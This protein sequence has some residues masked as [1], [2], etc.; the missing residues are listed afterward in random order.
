[1]GNTKNFYQLILCFEYITANRT[2]P[3]IW[4]D[5]IKISFGEENKCFLDLNKLNR[6]LPLIT[7]TPDSVPFEVKRLI[8]MP[9]N[10]NPIEEEFIAVENKTVS[11]L[12]D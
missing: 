5:L 11:D 1:M 9:R 10:K 6:K 7:L 8:Y 12:P 2:N 4:A 3:F